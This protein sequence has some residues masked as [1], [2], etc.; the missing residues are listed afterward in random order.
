MTTTKF[1]EQK[2]KINIDPFENIWTQKIQ[3]WEEAISKIVVEENEVTISDKDVSK[4]SSELNQSLEK[5]LSK[6]QSDSN[7]FDFS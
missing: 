5:N 3:K 7:T 6:H 4:T 1:E 2:N